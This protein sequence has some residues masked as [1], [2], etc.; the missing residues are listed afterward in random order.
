MDNNW[1]DVRISRYFL[2][3]VDCYLYVLMYIYIVWVGICFQSYCSILLTYLT[4][5]CYMTAIVCIMIEAVLYRS[6]MYVLLNC[7]YTVMT[8]HEYW[9]P[10]VYFTALVTLGSQTP[11]VILT[12]EVGVGPD[13][14]VSLPWVLF[15][16]LEKP[17]LLPATVWSVWWR[18][19]YCT[20][21]R[22]FVEELVLTRKRTPHTT[23][24]VSLSIWT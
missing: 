14:W 5:W 6:I 10:C 3:T 11:L 7:D 1:R 24:P 23:S 18:L 20:V 4:E 12:S 22:V 9:L 2:S 16:S 17:L 8:V 21:L 19:K 15:G 13:R